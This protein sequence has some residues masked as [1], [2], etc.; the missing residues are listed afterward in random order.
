M[1]T[2]ESVSDA[3]GTFILTNAPVAMRMGTIN[4]L[5]KK[6]GSDIIP[7]DA[8][9]TEDLESLLNNLQKN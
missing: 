4:E 3:G 8:T 9:K 1:K 6:T 2:A 7:A 5:A